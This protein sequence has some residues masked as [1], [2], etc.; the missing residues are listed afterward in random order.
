MAGKRGMCRSSSC[1]HPIIF[2]PTTRRR[3]HRR[4]PS[5]ALV[6]LLLMCLLVRPIVG[7]SSALHLMAHAQ[8]E[9]STVSPAGA[10]GDIDHERG[11]HHLMH[12]ACPGGFALEVAPFLGVPPYK[13]AVAPPATD[14]SDHPLR[15]GGTPFRPPIAVAS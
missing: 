8:Q 11:S 9:S 15:I 13:P 12:H 10:S 1:S 6:A 4:L 2:M 14:Q 7:A 3:R 5:L